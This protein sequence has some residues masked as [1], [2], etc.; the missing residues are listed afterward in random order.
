MPCTA[1]QPE[2]IGRLRRLLTEK[3]SAAWLGMGWTTWMRER[4]KIEHIRLGKFRRY[5]EEFLV[6][7]QNSCRV[8]PTQAGEP[9]AT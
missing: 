2:D 1:K 9:A 3:Q 7:Y 8:K 4:E 5:T 6:R